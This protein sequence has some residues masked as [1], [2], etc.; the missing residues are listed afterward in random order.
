MSYSK[1]QCND[2]CLKGIALHIPNKLQPVVV[3]ITL[4]D[5]HL[6]HLKVKQSLHFMS[7]KVLYPK[8]TCIGPV[9]PKDT[10]IVLDNFNWT[11]I[12]DRKSY[13]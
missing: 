9:Q 4:F 2:A 3:A 1:N 7:S 11:H 13:E 12:I 5:E 6:I 10:L 8:L